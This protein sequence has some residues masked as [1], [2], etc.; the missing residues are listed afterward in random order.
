MKYSWQ[1]IGLALGVSSDYLDDLPRNHDTPSTNLSKVISK[2]MDSQ[3]SP[4][5]W[6]TVISAIEGP[7]VDNKRKADEIRNYLGNLIIIIKL[8]V[9]LGTIYD[10]LP[11]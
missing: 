3:P 2:W 7:F 11:V 1:E 4:V 9:M 8:I 5:T 6:K 10:T